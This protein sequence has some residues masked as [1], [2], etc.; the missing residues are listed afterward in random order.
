MRI[1]YLI[2]SLCLSALLVAC[3]GGHDTPPPAQDKRLPTGPALLAEVERV[4]ATGG[5]PGLSVVVVD[6]D[7]IEA[8]S[9][10]RRN[11]NGPALITD[12]DQFQT[13]S[14]TKAASALLIARLVE[15]NKLRWDSTM[16][17][18]FPAWTAQMQASLRSVT[19]QQLLRHRSG[20]K[21]DIEE[22]DAVQLRPHATGNVGAD[23]ATVG[24]YFLQL[25]PAL[26]PDT[27][28]SYSN[29]G[30]LIVGLIAEAVGGESYEALM[31]KEVFGPLNMTASFGLPEDGGP[32]A[33]S[34]HVKQANAWVAAQY[35][36]ETRLWL[37]LMYPAG[38]MKI[39]MADY[40]KYLHEHL[41][42]LQGKSAYLSAATYKLI[43]TPVDGYGF[44]WSVG[45][46]A[47][48]G[49]RYSVHN[50]TIL[51]YYSTTILV[52]GTGRA[53]A[54]SCNCYAENGN[55]AA[56]KLLLRLVGAKS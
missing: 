55:D 27:K 31:Q 54:V 14:L 45:D 32:G 53:V 48:I 3:G 38:G 13:G 4:R 20:I 43:H 44:G 40:G 49:G 7:R 28:Y 5:L 24:R 15:Q 41:R 1:K 22:V 17:E 37:R 8:V 10:G 34:G 23:R 29:V 30:Y 16:G 25:A 12:A 33:L 47:D 2:G 42:G 56:E 35:S 19:V 26:T 18:I 39:S 50:G 46:D 6:Q 52:P 11:I 9:T 36:D 51:T 21:R